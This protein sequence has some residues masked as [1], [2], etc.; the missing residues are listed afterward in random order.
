[1]VYW[2]IPKVG[3]ELYEFIEAQLILK[4]FKRQLDIAEITSICRVLRYMYVLTGQY[5]RYLLKFVDV[6]RSK[7][8]VSS[9]NLIHIL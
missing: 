2:D 1:M 6:C 3:L 4:T 7:R 8:I 9:T 5:K